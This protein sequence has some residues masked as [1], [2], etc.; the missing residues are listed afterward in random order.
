MVY[1]VQESEIE[2][3]LGDEPPAIVDWTH[4]DENV[5]DDPSS[6]FLDLHKSVKDFEHEPFFFSL[7]DKFLIHAVELRDVK[8]NEKR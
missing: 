4:I 3:F 1:E 2:L 7:V 6:A 5:G 8:E